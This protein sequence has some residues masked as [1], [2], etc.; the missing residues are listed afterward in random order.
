MNFAEICW[1]P[2][3]P[4]TPNDLPFNSVT[5]LISGR[6]TKPQNGRI[7]PRNTIFTG[8][9]RAADTKLEPALSV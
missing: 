9:P 7:V 8:K 5:D 3:K 1:D 6:T 2:S 4:G